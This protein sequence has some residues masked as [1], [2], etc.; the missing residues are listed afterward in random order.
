MVF[1]S[2]AI[3]IQAEEIGKQI[4]SEAAQ[5]MTELGKEAGKEA[6]EFI[7]SLVG[8]PEVLVIGIALII[9]AVVVLFL[10]KRIVINSILGLIAWSILKYYFQ[11]ELPF[12]ASLAVSMLFGLAG[13]GTLLILKFFGVL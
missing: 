13:V 11:V 6:T 3:N 7:T 1:S 8:K 9:I 2:F 5:H 4:A 12:M 10:I